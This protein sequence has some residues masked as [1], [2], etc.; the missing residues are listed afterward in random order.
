MS[1]SAIPGGSVVSGQFVAAWFDGTGHG[2]TYMQ[3]TTSADTP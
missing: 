1:L 3:P 2:R